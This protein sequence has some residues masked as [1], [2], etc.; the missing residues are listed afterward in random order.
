M[1]HISR[2]ADS[3][4]SDVTHGIVSVT[5]LYS[6]AK[7][8]TFFIHIWSAHVSTVNRF[9]VTMSP[10]YSLTCRPKWASWGRDSFA[11]VPNVADP[12]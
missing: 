2:G 4:K 3:V 10:N 5:V 11:L 9:L 12:G 8:T 6:M 1:S 7:V